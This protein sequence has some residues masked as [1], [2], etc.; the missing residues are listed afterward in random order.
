MKLA[1]AARLHWFFGAGQ[2]VLGCSSFGHVLEHAGLYRAALMDDAAEARI[3]AFPTSAR[4]RESSWT[5]DDVAL[6]L[7]GRISRHLAR[8]NEG[9]A[10]ASR[11]FELVH[12][13]FGVIWSNVSDEGALG[14][15]YAFTSSGSR[16]LADL[17]HHSKLSMSDHMRMQNATRA[18]DAKTR[19]QISKSR[20]EALATYERA[21]EAYY[22]H[23]T[24]LLEAAQ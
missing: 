5:P 4:Q 1:D 24:A 11:V 6:R 15:L 16:L 20:A 7:Y 3:T 19:N 8:A 10:H 21:C 18:T 2:H 13:D 17:K 22:G 9:F 12:G 23:D 14:A